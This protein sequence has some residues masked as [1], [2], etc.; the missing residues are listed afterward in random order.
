MVIQRGNGRGA[1]LGCDVEDTEQPVS[2]CRDLASTLFSSAER[3]WL[4]S[5]PDTRT[6]NERFL[7]L[8]LQKEAQLKA[9]GS[10]SGIGSGKRLAMLAHVWL[11]V[12]TAARKS[13]YAYRK[14]TLHIL[15]CVPNRMETEY[16]RTRGAPIAEWNQRIEAEGR[17]FLWIPGKIPEAESGQ[18]QCKPSISALIPPWT[19][20]R[21]GRKPV[22][23]LV[24]VGGGFVIKAPQEGWPVCRRMNENVIA[25]F[26]LE[27]RIFSFILS[28]ILE[29]AKRPM[30]FFRFGSGEW[31][32]D[33]EMIGMVGFS[34][35]GQVAVDFA[36]MFDPEDPFFSNGPTAWDWR[37]TTHGACLVFIGHP[38]VAVEGILT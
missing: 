3:E 8:Y 12:A 5:A 29:E 37:Q 30:R 24:C 2:C 20:Y 38:L 17:I 13:L 18:G 7:A 19:S 16:D 27:Y 9:S 28:T 10:G 32:I 22:A 15:S 23:L 14:S 33:P 1:V 31:G 21:Y 36:T 35:G 6:G 26:L 25:A 11:M 34:A 4:K